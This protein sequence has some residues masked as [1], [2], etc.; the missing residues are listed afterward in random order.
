MGESLRFLFDFVSPYSYLASTQI[1]GLASRHGREVEA[2][3][4]LFAGMLDATGNR[5]VAEI[6]AKRQN[7]YWDVV[8]IAR[9][10]GVRIE[11]P[12]THPFNPLT[13]LRATGCVSDPDARWRLV[14]ALY[15]AAWVDGRRVD[16]P[17]VVARVADEVGQ[18]GRAL[19]EQAA[20]AEAKARLRQATDE[21]VLAGAFGVPTVFAA[22]EMFWGVDSLPYLEGVLSGEKTMDPEGLARWRA[23]APSAVRRGAR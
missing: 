1:R 4:V 16:Q 21:A 14:D 20:S 5:G 2:V 13:A 18:D 22:G 8:R 15:E 23:V 3:P 19:L 9:G 11:P 7:M 12:A 17:E 10:L 6:P